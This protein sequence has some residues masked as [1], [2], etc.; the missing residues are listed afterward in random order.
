M[1]SGLRSALNHPNIF[2][3]GHGHAKI[4]DFGLAKLAPE[5]AV[6][7]GETATRT[8]APARRSHARWRPN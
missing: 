3:T 8:V 4:L 2:V 5:R 6:A 7:T 1:T